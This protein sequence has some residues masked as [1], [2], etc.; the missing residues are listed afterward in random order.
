MEKN[1]EYYLEMAIAPRI[2]LEKN[3]SI[4]EIENVIDEELDNADDG[5]D[6][7][8]INIDLDFLAY[9]YDENKII[10]TIEKLIPKYK[11]LGWSEIKFNFP[12]LVFK[13]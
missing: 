9:D 12:K 6:K 2:G 11:R 4:S 10:K 7:Q 5:T 13:K 3:K 1:F 8:T